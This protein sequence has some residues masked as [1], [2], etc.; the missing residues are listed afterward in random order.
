MENLKTIL[1]QAQKVHD[2]I[3]K[4]YNN[5]ASAENKYNLLHARFLLK[6]VKKSINALNNVPENIEELFDCIN[7]GGF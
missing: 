5:E 2:E 1:E 6:D 3:E 7:T 4:A